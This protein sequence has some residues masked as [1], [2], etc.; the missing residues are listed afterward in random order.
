MTGLVLLLIPLLA[1]VT[2]VLFVLDAAMGAWE[3]LAELPEV[4]GFAT[5]RT[6]QV[7][8]SMAAALVVATLAYLVA[9][10]GGWVLAVAALAMIGLLEVVALSGRPPHRLPRRVVWRLGF[11]P[12]LCWT[13]R[14]FLGW[15]RGRCGT[16]CP[17]GTRAD[18]ASPGTATARP[19]STLASTGPW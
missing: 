13:D 5:G 6:G 11:W 8:L 10:H 4:A 15:S 17:P 9:Q 18:S 19:P 3:R 14:L 12:R 16:G 7:M 1:L 2:V